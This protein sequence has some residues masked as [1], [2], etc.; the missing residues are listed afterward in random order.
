MGILAHGKY[1]VKYNTILSIFKI[2]LNLFSSLPPQYWRNLCQIG[3]I[4]DRDTMSGYF[5]VKQPADGW[6][7]VKC[8]C[9][10]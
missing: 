8:N 5:L 1:H 4:L 7:Q 9:V 6:T 10:T 3:W 2:P